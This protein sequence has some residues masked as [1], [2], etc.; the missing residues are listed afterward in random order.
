[1]RD[2]VE[3]IV[4]ISTLYMSEGQVMYWNLK[5]HVDDK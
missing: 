3:S 1:M 4:L 5:G 2:C